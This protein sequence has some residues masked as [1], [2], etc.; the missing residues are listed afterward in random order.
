[1][2]LIGLPFNAKGLPL[3]PAGW[4]DGNQCKAYTQGSPLH[5]PRHQEVVR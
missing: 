1:M 4:W 2:R 5:A 3:F